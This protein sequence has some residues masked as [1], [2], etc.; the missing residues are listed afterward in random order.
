[1]VSGDFNLP[2]IDWDTDSVAEKCN[3]RSTH[4]KFLEIE[5]S[6]SSANGN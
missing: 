4:E 5:N 1:M 3:N 6:L 2:H